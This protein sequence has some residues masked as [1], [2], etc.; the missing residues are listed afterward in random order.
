MLN[1]STPGSADYRSEEINI[2]ISNIKPGLYEAIL[3]NRLRDLLAEAGT[4]LTSLSDLEE[5]EA[6]LLLSNHL[7]EAIRGRWSQIKAQLSVLKL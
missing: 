4:T 3:N 2:S 5:S 6:P 7:A 1:L